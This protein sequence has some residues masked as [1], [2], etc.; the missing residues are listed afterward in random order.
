V[1]ILPKINIKKISS[2]SLN[3]IGSKVAKLDFPKYNIMDDPTSWICRVEQYFI[4]KQIEEREKL[5]L[6]AYRLDGVSQ[7]WYQLF[8]KNEE[9]ITWESLKATLYIRYGPTTFD[10]HF[11]DLTKL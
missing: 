2:S 11:G 10:D 4:F 8:K 3:N 5:P 1:R 7:M 9:V 6:A